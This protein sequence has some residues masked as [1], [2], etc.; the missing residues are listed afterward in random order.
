MVHVQFNPELLSTLKDKV[1]VLTGGATGI[2]AGSKVVFGDVNEAPARELEAG[3]GPAV[4]FQYCDTSSYTSQLDLFALAE[5]IYG[6]VDVVVANAGVA[7]HKD[8]FEAGSDIS[9]EPSMREVDINLKGPIFTARIGMHHLRKNGSRN[10]KGG[11]D[12]V[13]VSS[14]AGFKESGGLATYTASKH[15]VLGLMRGLHTTVVLEGIRINV[16]CPWMTKTKLVKG[17]EAGWRKLGLPENEAEDVARS[18]VLCASAN[19]SEDGEVHPG[20]KMPF[21]GKILWI[22]GGEAYEIEDAIQDLEPQWLGEENSKVLAK[23]QEFL[24]S[25]GTS[26]DADKLSQKPHDAKPLHRE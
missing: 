19:R 11:G 25:Q 15:G 21:A 3:L 1:V 9:V 18:I 2:E 26:W 16:I 5:Q 22:A 8:I 14:I 6:R 13:L 12:L 10:G 4:R 20:A 17:I 7:I 23:G 24:A